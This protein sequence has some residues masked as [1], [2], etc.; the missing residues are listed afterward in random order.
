MTPENFDNFVF[1]LFEKRKNLTAET[2][3][4]DIWERTACERI[5]VLANNESKLKHYLVDFVRKKLKLE[6]RDYLIV[7]PIYF[8]RGNL[9]ISMW[10]WALTSSGS[11]KCHAECARI[12]GDD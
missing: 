8:W 10:A 1:E 3:Y 5:R 12:F 11:Y 9:R 4:N 7:R 2:S 6:K